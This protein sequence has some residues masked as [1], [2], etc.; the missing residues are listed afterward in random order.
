MAMK[1]NDAQWLDKTQVITSQGVRIIPANICGH[2]VLLTHRLNLHSGYR[3]QMHL[4]SARDVSTC[5]IVFTLQCNL[6]CNVAHAP[7][8]VLAKNVRRSVK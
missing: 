5:D 8:A 7:A 1:S 2:Y 6:G 3:R 4:T